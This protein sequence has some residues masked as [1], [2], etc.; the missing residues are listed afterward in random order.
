MNILHNRLKL[1]MLM[2][3]KSLFLLLTINIAFLFIYSTSVLAEVK[4]SFLYYLSDFN[5]PVPLNMVNLSVDEQRNEIYVVDPDGGVVRVFNARGMEV[6]EF[7]DNGDLGSI[8]DVAVRDDGNI[9]VLTSGTRNPS[10]TLCNFRGEPLS[11]LELKNLPPDFSDFAPGY[12]VSRHGLLYVL[13]SNSGRIVVCDPEGRVQRGYD[14]ISLMGIAESKRAT[15][16]IPGFSVD[17]KGNILFTVPVLFHAFRL[18][19]EGELASFGS[20]GSSPGK[21]NIAG[22]IVSDDRGYYYVADR[23]KSAIMVFDENFGFIEEFGYRGSRP[24]N[25][26]GP[27]DLAL[28]VNGN[29]YVSQIA[30]RGVSVF[31]ITYTEEFNK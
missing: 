9:L 30:S 29:L 2:T 16:E 10:L 28:D 31:N 15:T 24:G 27:N 3:K 25:L 26:I 19:P 21:F 17:P 12:I 7:G 1:M 8:F 6:Y 20:P 5:G 13:D 11:E 18:T 23:L 22:G 14:L 4:T